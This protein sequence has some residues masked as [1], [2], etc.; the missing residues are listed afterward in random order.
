M[1]QATGI[2]VCCLTLGAAPGS[3]GNLKSSSRV[4][5]KCPSQSPQVQLQQ[6]CRSGSDPGCTLGTHGPRLCRMTWNKQGL[7]QVEEWQRT[8]GVQNFFYI[9]YGTIIDEDEKWSGISQQLEYEIEALKL[10]H[11]MILQCCFR[12]CNSWV[13]VLMMYYIY[14]FTSS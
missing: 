6:A 13:S 8:K 5:S 11:K 9:H 3:L 2:S 10:R 12:A 7:H 4:R 14:V 1:D